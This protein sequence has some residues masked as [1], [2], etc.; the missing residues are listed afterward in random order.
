MENKETGGGQ[1]STGEVVLD[2]RMLL[3]EPS[4]RHSSLLPVPD[5]YDDNDDDSDNDDD[6]DSCSLNNDGLK[7]TVF[8]DDMSLSKSIFS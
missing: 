1:Q 6:T 3:E 5:V 2:E 7:T 4:K 8:I